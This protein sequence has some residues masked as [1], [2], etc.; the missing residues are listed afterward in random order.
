MPSSC[1]TGGFA[2]LVG[3]NAALPQQSK[4]ILVSKCVLSGLN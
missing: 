4:L 1:Q 3:A 2:K